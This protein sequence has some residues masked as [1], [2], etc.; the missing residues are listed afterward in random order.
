MWYTA[1]SYERSVAFARADSTKCSPR[2]AGL[3]MQGDRQLFDRAPGARTPL[4]LSDFMTGMLAALAQRGVTVLLNRSDRLDYAF[5]QLFEEI[6][7]QA[8]ASNLDL[9]FFI[10]TH[11][12][13][14]DSDDVQQ[15]LTAA[16]GRDLISLDNPEYQVVRFKIRP[17]DA[18]TYLR[19]LPGSPELYDSLAGRFLELYGTTTT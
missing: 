9:R 15:E 12:Q 4:Y 14:G 16:A 5:E 11:P 8:D 18:A 17:K 1:G 13:Y 6:E 7:R 3:A 2:E 10:Q 19:D